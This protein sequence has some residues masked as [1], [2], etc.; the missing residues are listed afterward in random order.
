MTEELTVV[1]PLPQEISQELKEKVGAVKALAYTYNFLD[2]TPVL[3]SQVE[4]HRNTLG[5]IHELYTKVIEDALAYPDAHLSPDLE[6]LKRVM[7]V[8]DGNAATVQ[9]ADKKIL[10]E[11]KRKRKSRGKL[12]VVKK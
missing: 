1:P 11:E 6:H 7:E 3:Q 8:A 5:F 4:L 12:N 9:D 10:A 2:K